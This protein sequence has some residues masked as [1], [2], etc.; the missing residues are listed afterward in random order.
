MAHR[1]DEFD[2]P[3][4]TDALSQ[5]E[6]QRRLA[7]LTETTMELKSAMAQLTS[8]MS[9]QAAAMSQQTAAMSQQAATVSTL[10][11][12]FPYLVIVTSR[13]QPQELTLNYTSAGSDGFGESDHLR[14]SAASLHVTLQL[15]MRSQPEIIEIMRDRLQSIQEDLAAFHDVVCACTADT[16]NLRSGALDAYQQIAEHFEFFRPGES[17]TISLLGLVDF[18][19]EQVARI[20]E[21]D[22]SVRA[23]WDAQIDSLHNKL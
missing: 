1:S 6:V 10:F 5:E 3:T 22:E 2:P 18:F 12:L 17:A 14:H 8:A 23:V 21:V 11:A 15:R 13:H 4:S 19:V 16:G 20:A 9:Q 7:Q